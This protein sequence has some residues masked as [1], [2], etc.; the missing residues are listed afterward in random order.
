MIHIDCLLK[1]QV[2]ALSVI[3]IIFFSCENDDRDHDTSGLKNIHIGLYIDN[4]AAGIDEVES[5][6]KQLG[7]Y[8][9]TINKDSILTSNLSNYDILIFPGGDMWVYKSHLSSSGVQKIKDYVRLGGGYLGIC[10]G[11]YFAANKIVWRGWADEPRQ[12]FTNTGLGIFSG[13]A[14]GPIEDYAPSYQDINCKVIINQNHPI[15][16][17]IPQQIE[18]LYSFGPKFIIED[19]SNVSILGKSASGDNSLVL[20]VQYEQGRLF[21]TSLH[22]EFDNDKSSWKM[23]SNALLWCSK[24]I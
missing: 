11:S 12:Y 5:M 23:I 1:K 16:Y 17:E 10:G 13:T 19:S 9:S 18:Y 6:L 14:D 8:Y 21:L 3:L 20:A 15:T 4:G 2:F 7:C 22:P 24:K